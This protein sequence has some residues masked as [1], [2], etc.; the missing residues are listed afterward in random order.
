M[1]EGKRSF[2]ATIP[3][4]VTGLA[5]LLTGIVGLITVLIQLD[6]IGGGASKDAGGG[7]TTTV[8][9]PGAA[10]PTT[11]EL[12]RITVNPTALKLAPTEREKTLTVRND[13]ATAAITVLNPALDGPDKA[14]FK[15]DSGCTNIRLEPGRSCTMKVL[16]TPS[17]PLKSYSATLVV[18][19]DGTPRTTEVPIDASTLLG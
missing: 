10:T 18:K 12:G 17:G 16:F 1:S 2:F 7:V 9:A 6:V 5:G 4:L 15:T 13:G 11:A 3:G 19:A 8:A 14:V